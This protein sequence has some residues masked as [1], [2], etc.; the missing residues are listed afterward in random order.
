MKLGCEVVKVCKCEKGRVPDCSS[1]NILSNSN[2]VLTNSN[3]NTESKTNAAKNV[4]L[5]SNLN[6]HN[7]DNKNYEYEWEVHYKQLYG[8]KKGEIFITL[9]HSIVVACG[10]AQV[11]VSDNRLLEKLKGFEGKVVCARD[12]K[13]IQN[14]MFYLEYLSRL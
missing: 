10:K 13:N 5:N 12:V 1:G 6:L 2:N 7:N 8:P 11:P 3:T 9:S 14:Y 4:I